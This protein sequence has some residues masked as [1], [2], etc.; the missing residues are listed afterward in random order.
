MVGLVAVYKCVALWS[1]V[2]GASA[3]ERP[4]GTIRKKKGNYSRF[5]V[6]VSSQ[7]VE[8][9]VTANSFLPFNQL[10]LGAAQGSLAFFGGVSQVTS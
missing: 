7:Y 5:Q 3:T 1:A 10:M 8:S 4:L 2:S 9:D 6:S